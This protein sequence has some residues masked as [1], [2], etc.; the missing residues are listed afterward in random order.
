MLIRPQNLG[1][2]LHAVRARITAAALEAGRNEQ[3]ITLLAVTK[4]HPAVAIEAAE[5]LGQRHFGENYLQEALPKIA[6]LRHLDLEWHFIGQLQSNKTRSVAEE[7][8]W[9]H[10]LQSPRHA[11]RLAA[12]RPPLAPPLNVCLQVKLGDEPSK[13]GTSDA[14]VASLARVV[15]RLPQLRLRGLMCLPPAEAETARQ[16]HW[17]GQLRALAAGLR[18]EFPSLDTLSMGMSGDLEAAIAEGATIVR[19]GTAIFGPRD[20]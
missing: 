7:F 10:T 12:Q 15:T 17:F 1:V 9:V 2:N 4:G 13:G 19:V 14:D 11:E 3:C 18:G 5:Q 20:T 16:R 8:A 6:A